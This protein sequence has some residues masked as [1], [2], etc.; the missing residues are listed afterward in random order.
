MTLPVQVTFRNIS[1]SPTIEQ[2][3]RE[4]ASDLEQYYSHITD[5]R[6]VVEVPHQHQLVGDHYRVRI[7]ITVPGGEVL[8][9]REPSLHS[10]QQDIQEEE[11]TKQ[12][13][14]EATRRYVQVAINEAFDA[15]RRRLQDFARRQRLDVKTRRGR[16]HGH[17]S[18][19][20]PKQHCGY[21]DAGLGYE[22]YFHENSVLNNDF[23][24]LSVGTE[25]S[26]A[27]EEGEKGPQASTVKALGSYRRQ[28]AKKGAVAR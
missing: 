24:N 8:V 14:I 19:L 21:I 18:R 23:K 6:V 13:E 10:R 28:S 26:F 22:V 2:L 16:I 27:E 12:R 25:V 3:V 15:A 7:R 9:N 1:P 17:V 11:R 4:Q 5:C 20:E